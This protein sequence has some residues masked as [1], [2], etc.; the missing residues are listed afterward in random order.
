LINN[1]IVVSAGNSSSDD[2]TCKEISETGLHIFEF[3]SGIGG[4]RCSLPDKLKVATITAFDVSDTP[5]NVYSENFES[6]VD[7]VDGYRGSLRRILVDGLKVCDVDGQADVWTMSPPCQPF[8]ETRNA[9][10]LDDKDNRSKGFFHLMFLL[11]C[12]KKRPRY[13]V[14]E[15][16]K[17]FI[18]SKVLK[19]WK[20]VLVWCGYSFR[21][22]L[23]SPI[24]SLGIP[25][26]RNRYYMIIE[27]G[28][29]F[30]QEMNSNKIHTSLGVDVKDVVSIS[31]YISTNI[32]FNI[33]KELYIDKAI[34]DKP[35]ASKR[36]SIVGDY[37][38]TSFCFTKSYGHT[39]DK[40]AGS[41]YL[42]NAQ[43][44]LSDP[45]FIDRNEL[46]LLFRRIRLFLPRE[47]LKLFGFPETFKFPESMSKRQQ[48]S[49]IGKSINVSVV[50]QVM[51]ELFLA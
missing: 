25:N 28:E 38:K 17:G 47:L 14:L 44:P 19:I 4:M 1:K 20:R 43:G 48:Y 49:C 11:I 33:D 29:R 2:T 13:I 26:H 34:L 24:T 8:T 40:S 16:V 9:N 22:Y 21:Q 51:K 41:Y 35:W 23:L 31:N 12:M 18:G 45:T 7:T 3:F 6:G 15:N 32:S 36:L 46:G 27:H 5:N 50:R 37:D 39:N 10:R 30:R 42:E